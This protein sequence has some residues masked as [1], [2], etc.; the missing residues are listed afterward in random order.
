MCCALAAAERER[1]SALADLAALRAA[2]AEDALNALMDRAARA[3]TGKCFAQ[4]GEWSSDDCD[5]EFSL[6]C[7]P[8][9]ERE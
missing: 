8:E 1:D 3:V 6:F 7:A 4:V 2:V 9:G 5:A